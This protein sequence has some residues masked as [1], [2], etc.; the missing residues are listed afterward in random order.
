MLQVRFSMELTPLTREQ[1][2]QVDQVV[3]G[4]FAQSAD[5][6]SQVEAEWRTPADSAAAPAP[7][8]QSLASQNLG[9]FCSF[10]HQVD[11]VIVLALEFENQ[12]K[13]SQSPYG[14]DRLLFVIYR[15]LLIADAESGQTLDESAIDAPQAIDLPS[16]PKSIE[17]AEEAKKTMAR[18]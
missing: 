14:S 15:N 12:Q 2:A 6:Y 18:V 16:L 9:L 4:V 11:D 1:I 3:F 10:H 7:G 5:D 17:R 8:E 13:V